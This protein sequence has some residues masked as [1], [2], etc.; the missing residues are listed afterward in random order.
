MEN[1]EPNEERQSVNNDPKISAVGIKRSKY[2]C[3]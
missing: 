1:V 3:T 2:E